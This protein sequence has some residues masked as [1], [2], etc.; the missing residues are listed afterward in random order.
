[1]LAC[2]CAGA[3]AYISKHVYACVHMRLAQDRVA[4]RVGAKT[5]LPLHGHLVRRCS[6]FSTMPVA[7]VHRR[8]GREATQWPSLRRAACCFNDAGWDCSV[9]REQ[10][11]DVVNK[12]MC[13][14]HSDT[15]IVQGAMDLGLMTSRDRASW[16]GRSTEVFE[17]DSQ[18]K[19]VQMSPELLR[20]KHSATRASITSSGTSTTA[21]S[22]RHHQNLD[23][24]SKPASFYEG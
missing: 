13:V 24:R 8:A 7:P 11:C 16:N 19:R 14:N 12:R 6:C 23:L 10:S 2:V 15:R 5:R 1:M 9:A 22:R 18:R 17:D 3:C 20:N 21:R 4:S